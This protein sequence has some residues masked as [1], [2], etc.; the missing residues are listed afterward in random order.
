MRDIVHTFKC[1]VLVEPPHL[2]RFYMDMRV[3]EILEPDHLKLT[4]VGPEELLWRGI[5]LAVE[6][7]AG[8]VNHKTKGR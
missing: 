3:Y 4:D 5:C 8:N 2:N 1:N 7:S 6:V